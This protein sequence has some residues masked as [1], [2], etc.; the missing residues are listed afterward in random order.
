MSNTS[1]AEAQT[2]NQSLDSLL[3]ERLLR[4]AGALPS[5]FDFYHMGTVETGP[6]GQ[7]LSFE[8]MCAFGYRIQGDLVGTLIL[9]FDEGQDSS[10]YSEMGN[11]LAS[12]I[13]TAL[14]NRDEIYLTVSPPTSLTNAT[15]RILL[16]TTQPAYRRTYLHIHENNTTR[17]EAIILASPFDEAKTF[18]A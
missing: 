11:I 8:S 3:N 16:Q 2:E 1:A 17:V 14:G 7:E 12:R 13:A 5:Q 10:M 15:V 4:L 6:T 9:L 18:Y